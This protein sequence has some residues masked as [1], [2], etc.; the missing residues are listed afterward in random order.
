M[1]PS[2]SP[3]ASISPSK[4]PSLSP[5]ISPSKS[6]SISPSKSPSVS[7]SISPSASPSLSPS[8]SISP[9]KSPSMSPSVSPSPSPSVSPS[10]S[11]SWTQYELPVS[12]SQ[13]KGIYLAKWEGLK[14]ES[15]T[16]NIGAPFACPSYPIKSVQVVG[17]WGG[18]V[19]TIQGSNWDDRATATYDTLHNMQ[20]TNM[21]FTGDT[22]R[23]VQEN[24]YWVRPII[25]GGGA[26]TDI[27]V[28]ILCVTER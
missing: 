1:S 23:G 10:V 27:D 12:L 26:T 9:S 17:T 21:Q 11:P 4:S 19:C 5:S 18:A 20:G 24:T 7:P 2:L 16:F 13:W 15:S 8:S 28:Y 3:S 22:L 14:Q 6:P 25:T